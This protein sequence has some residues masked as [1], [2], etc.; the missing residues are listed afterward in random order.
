MVFRT[1][2][3]RIEILEEHVARLENELAVAGA[4]PIFAVQA[5]LD[6]M[7]DRRLL[8]SEVR[9]AIF[10]TIR[11]GLSTVRVGSAKIG[12]GAMGAMP[13]YRRFSAL[14]HG[15]TPRPERA[16]KETLRVREQKPGIDQ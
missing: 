6:E 7:V 13:T 2:R 9:T 8:A 12:F 15:E 5:V 10:E 14:K 1:D 4:L 11:D 3:E 16:R